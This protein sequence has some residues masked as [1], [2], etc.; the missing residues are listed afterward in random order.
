MKPVLFFVDDEPHNLTVFEA[1]MPDEWQVITFDN[2]LKALEALET[3]S[4]WVI[5]SDQRMPGITGV[6]FLELAKKLHPNA[7]RII[8]TGYSEEDLV[9]ESVRKAQIFD[10]IKKPWEPDD[11]QAS[12]SRSIEFYKASQEGRRLTEELQKRNVELEKTARELESARLREEGFRKEL[13]CWVP[14]FVLK[15]LEEKPEN[16][17][18]K[19]DIVGIAFDI[20]ESSAIHNKYVGDRPLR[21][22]VIQAF[23]ESLLRH[24]GWRESHSGDSAYG[25]F[26]LWENNSNPF[27]GALAAAR[28]FRV[29]LKSIADVH[30]IPIECGVAL[31]VVRGCQVDIHK[32]QLNTASGSITQKSFDTSSIEID[33]L[34]RMEKLV[35][36]LPGTNI[37]M[38]EDF[39]R[40]LRISPPQVKE[41]GRFRFKGQ[42]KATQLFLFPSDRT[43][44][45]HLEL[46]RQSSEAVADL[47]MVP[48][49]P[50]LKAA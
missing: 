40:S 13:E 25:H 9:V 5:I 14:P 39:F 10:Y 11:L 23:S 46:V 19:R 38:S 41:L 49:V 45:E 35:H 30:G 36:K 24:G 47:E 17:P 22:F 7:V 28:E 6:R 48:V 20:I 29:A 15:F 27:E 4:P 31:H 8:V 37:V 2:P 1:A 43:T 12:I 42:E 18:L 26:G 44:A 33:L 32:V 3:A 21:S 34:H 50:V 16:L